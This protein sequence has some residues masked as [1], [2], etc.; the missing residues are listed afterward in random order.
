MSKTLVNTTVLGRGGRH[1]EI[2]KVTIIIA[3]KKTSMVRNKW[4]YNMNIHTPFVCGGRVNTQQAV[5]NIITQPEHQ[6]N[7]LY[8]NAL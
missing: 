1:E 2:R 6:A 3:L 5:R 4:I 7:W 8:E